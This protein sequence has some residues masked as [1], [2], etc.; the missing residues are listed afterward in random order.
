MENELL[1]D[2]ENTADKDTWCRLVE[3]GVQTGEFNAVNPEVVMDSFL[4][5]Y[6]GVE[7]WGRILPFDT[8]TFDHITEAVRILLIKNYGRSDI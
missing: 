3:Y 7:M 2:S 1:L 8:K 6:R 5:A 4:Y